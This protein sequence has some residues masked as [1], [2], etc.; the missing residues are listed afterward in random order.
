MGIGGL[1]G[2]GAM[3]GFLSMARQCGCLGRASPL[4]ESLLYLCVP[5]CCLFFLACRC[6]PCVSLEKKT[7]ARDRKS[8]V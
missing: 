1:L 6:W 3:I 7:L 5:T 8:V 2:G 4:C